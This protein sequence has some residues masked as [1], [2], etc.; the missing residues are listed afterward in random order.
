MKFKNYKYQLLILVT[1]LSLT[2]LKL[3]AY[4]LTSSDSIKIANKYYDLGLQYGKK[5]I[6]DSALFYTQLS[7]EIYENN[8]KTD[9]TFLANAYQ[10]IGIINKL[11]GKYLEAIKYYD[12]A[13]KIYIAENNEFLLALV[14]MN[15]ANI[16]KVQQDYSKAETFLNRSVNI[17]N[18]DSINNK[19]RLASAY[20]NL[21]NIYLNQKELQKAIKYYLKSIKLKRGSKRSYATYGNLA[22]CYKN[23]YNYNL[24]EIYYQKAINKAIEYYND[25]C[26]I[27][28]ALHYNNYAI[29]LSE[30]NDR[31]Q[32]SHYFNLVNKIYINNFGLKHPSISDYFNELGNHYVRYNQ[33]DSALVYFQQALIALAPDYNNEDFFTNPSINEVL[34]KTHFLTA[35]KNKAN[36]LSEL[37]N[38]KKDTEY[39]KQSLITYDLAIDVI[40]KIRSGYISEESKLFLADNEFETF[41]K[42]LQTCFD[43][44]QLTKGKIYLEKA[45]NY[46]EAGKSAILTEALQ[47]NQALNIGGIPDSLLLQEKKLEKSI[48]G[49]EELIYEETKK[50]SPDQNKL[51]YWNKYL[52]EEKQQYDHLISYLEDHYEEYFSL[53]HVKNNFTIK[54]LQKNLKHKDLLLEYFFTNDRLYTFTISKHHSDIYVN[55]IDSLFHHHLDKLLASLSNNNFSEHGYDEFNQYQESSLYIYNQLLK[56]FENKIKH[57]NLIIVPDG[58]LAYLPFEVLISEKNSYDRINY[59]DLPYLLYNHQFSYS[60]SAQF[61]MDN[62]KQKTA[63]KKLAAFAPTYN[64]I[65]SLPENYSS[66]RQEYREKLFPLKGIKVEVET[67]AKLLNGDSYI[68]NEA[69]EKTFKE[70]AA[71]YDILHLAM[72]TIMDDTNPMYSKMAFTQHVDSTEDGFLNTY[73]LYNMHLNSRMAVLSSC[74]SGSGKLHRGEGVMSMAR[75][76]IYSGCPSII[77][78]LWT[79]EDKSGVKLMTK[80][81]E[82]LLNGKSK[83]DALQES[84]IDFIQN[85][86][87]L[88]SHPYFWSGYVVIGNNSALFNSHLKYFIYLGIIVVLIITGILVKR[89]KN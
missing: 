25:S 17:F 70:I 28:I 51:E 38:Q 81:Y 75:G 84:K 78:T 57:K 42:A 87:Q 55:K 74:N 6:L 54:Q 48:W 40:G 30:Q 65:N 86:D 37:G 2:S 24:A 89:R 32:A 29:F 15:K 26:N 44:Y 77:M 67:I 68:G 27:N 31:T 22:I 1:I 41:S 16:F 46:S 60:Y 47:N 19:H 21:G 82:K 43:L 23:L 63:I 80:F 3:N 18:K 66:F 34:S 8:T 5:G 52:F 11:L 35:L 76:F 4:T 56:P 88:K 62:K 9:K 14:Y 33:P 64:N 73:E 13:E 61:L 83:S 71:D 10:S 50:K 39:L 53:K 49:Y 20:N 45:I 85:A 59:K 72:H 36:I 58:K 79:V 12:H 69:N 7:V